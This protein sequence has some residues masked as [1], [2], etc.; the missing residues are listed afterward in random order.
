LACQPAWLAGQ[1]CDG[2][3]IGSLPS[4]CAGL[5]GLLLAV[6]DGELR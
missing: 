3:R 5:L 4:A 6:P 1:A 2:A